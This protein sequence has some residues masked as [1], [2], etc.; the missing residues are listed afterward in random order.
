M[1][2]MRARCGEWPVL[3]LDEVLAELDADRRRDLL[4]RLNGAEQC[5]L[6]TTDLNLF[7]E[8]FRTR[9]AVWTIQSGR[10]IRPTWGSP[11]EHQ[12]KRRPA[13]SCHLPPAICL[14]ITVSPP[15]PA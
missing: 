10:V 5:V 3:L 13:A 7:P 9:A 1:E 8:A 6:T 2:W 15:T 14:L 12:K 11:G 4:D